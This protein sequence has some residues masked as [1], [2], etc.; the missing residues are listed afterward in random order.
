MRGH[1]SASVISRRHAS[2]DSS[3]VLAG[4]VRGYVAIRRSSLAQA[5]ERNHRDP[6]LTASAGPKGHLITGGTRYLYVIWTRSSDIRLDEPDLEL[7]PDIGPH[8]SGE[9]DAT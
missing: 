5:Q 6:F 1:E 3:G 9:R 2:D 4:Y 7:R 8:P